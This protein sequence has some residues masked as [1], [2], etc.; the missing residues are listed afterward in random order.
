MKKNLFR[1]IS[2]LF[3][4]S[5]LALSPVLASADNNGKGKKENNKQAKQERV[6]KREA[7]DD[8]DN[9]RKKKGSKCWTAYGHLIAFGWLKKNNPIEIGEDCYLPFG[10]AKKFRGGRN[11]STTPPFADTT[12]PTIYN[13]VV[14]PNFVKATISWTTNEKSDSTVFLGTATPVNIQS[15]TTKSITLG[16]KTLNHKVVINDLATSTTYHAV[17][18]SRDA[19]GNTATSSEFSFTTKT[20]VIISDTVSPTIFSVVAVV[21][22]STANVGWQ[23]NEA[24][25]S[26]IYYSTTT[27]LN[28]T[29][30][31]T[32]FIESLTL[33][34]VHLLK[35]TNLATST[36]Y[37][38]VVESKDA[39]ANTQR[40]N[41]FQIT[42]GS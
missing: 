13:I 40:S 3:I 19:S 8:D 7:E 22:T 11:A 5:T 14:N 20:P 33:S 2:L 10:I 32:N 34:T 38:M 17:V 30:S 1:D 16:S 26:K 24:A 42:T 36:T 12:A 27:P 18:R 25:A 21:G 6:E 28:L 15:S 23:T 35:L 29:A 39:A 41:E 9:G 37:Y 4:V 31:G